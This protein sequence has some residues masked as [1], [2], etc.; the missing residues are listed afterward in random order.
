[1]FSNVIPSSFFLTASLLA[2]VR[3]II[4]IFNSLDKANR[5]SAMCAYCILIGSFLHALLSF[6]SE[7]W[8]IPIISILLE[9][10]KFSICCTVGFPPN[11]FCVITMIGGLSLFIK[12]LM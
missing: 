4:G 11:S 3:P 5:S 9:R 7:Y 1:M 6:M 10:M 12:L 8:S 2:C